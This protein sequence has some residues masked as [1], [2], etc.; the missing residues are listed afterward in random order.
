MESRNSSSTRQHINCLEPCR[1]PSG[2]MAIM[3][4]LI[5][6]KNEKLFANLSLLALWRSMTFEDRPVRL[7]TE[8]YQPKPISALL[9]S[10]TLDDSIEFLR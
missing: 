5:G 2:K 7:F 3:T 1:M 10:L 6:L 8:A 4:Y 9:Q